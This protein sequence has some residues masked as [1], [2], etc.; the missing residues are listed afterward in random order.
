LPVELLLQTTRAVAGA[1]DLP[2]TID[3]EGGY[4]TCRRASAN[5]WR[6]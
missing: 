4:R 2:V 1:T 5:S 6:R 3:F